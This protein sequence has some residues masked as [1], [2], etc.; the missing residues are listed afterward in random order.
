LILWAK[1]GITTLTVG[2][3]VPAAA[4]RG[5]R[6]RH[7]CLYK[8]LSQSAISTFISLSAREFAPTAHFYK[9]LLDRSQ[10]PRFCEA[11]VAELKQQ[12]KDRHLLP[13]TIYLAAGRRP[14]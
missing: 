13:S 8:K 14:R 1:L 7:A 12:T 6:R 11:L 4:Q 5:E 2:A 3:A 9:E 10:T